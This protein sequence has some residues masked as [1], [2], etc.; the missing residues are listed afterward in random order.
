MAFRRSRTRG[1]TPWRGTKF[2]LRWT[3]QLTDK[4]NIEN[5]AI[6]TYTLVDVADYASNTALEPTGVTLMRIRGFFTYMAD[7]ATQHSIFAAVFVHDADA[8]PALGG[9]MDPS[10]FQ[11]VIDEQ[12]LWWWSSIF[13]GEATD[14]DFVRM[15]LDIKAK[16]RLHEDNVSL[17]LV[18]TGGAAG[19]VGKLTFTLRSLLKGAAT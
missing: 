17:V 8:V 5:N 18:G 2:P 7:L 15:E 6:S 14:R 13:L 9:L 3:S 12:V 11:Q 16:R 10:G 1:R 19:A 4:T